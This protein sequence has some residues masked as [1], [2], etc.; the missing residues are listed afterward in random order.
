MLISQLSAILYLADGN[1]CRCLH[2]L[3]NATVGDMI[4]HMV[5]VRPPV[6]TCMHA[7]RCRAF[8]ER[9]PIQ[10]MTAHSS[11]GAGGL[12]G[13][14][15]RREQ[16]NQ[17]ETRLVSLWLEAASHSN[18]FDRFFGF[19]RSRIHSFESIGWHMD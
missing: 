3:P 9:Q 16:S 1:E 17:H 6:T 8:N 4:E 12:A 7:F 2:L 18:T 11:L 10:E 19:F 5:L 13:Q 15:R 14:V